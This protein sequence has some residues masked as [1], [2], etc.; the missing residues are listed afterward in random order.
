LRDDAA[1][2]LHHTVPGWLAGIEDELKRGGR[3]IFTFLGKPLSNDV[4]E[5][6]LHFFV[7]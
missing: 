5:Y 7:C 1:K 2:Q 3:N 4:A 6:G